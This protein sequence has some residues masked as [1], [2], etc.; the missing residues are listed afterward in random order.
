MTTEPLPVPVPDT[1]A[2]E[3]ESRTFLRLPLTPA[4]VELVH[5]TYAAWE[6]T[7]TGPL[8]KTLPGNRHRPIGFLPLQPA[9]TAEM[10]DSYYYRRGV[11]LP[12]ALCDQ[13][14]ALI[15]LLAPVARKIGEQIAARG[16]PRLLR[17]T[18]RGC[19]RVMRYPPFEGDI[20][21]AMVRQ[22]AQRGT[23][24][25]PAHKD[26]N[27]LTILAPA[28]LPGLQ[29]EGPDGWAEVHDAGNELIVHT[30][31]EMEDRSGRRW[32]AT[33]HRVRNPEPGDPQLAR[34]SCAY[35]V[36]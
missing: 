18:D 21:S 10:K 36:S 12:Q 3:L 29:I 6:R 20:D 24:R 11:R 1:A 15:A 2:A 14:D 25:S 30:G 9:F 26:L 5:V 33:V 7:L 28:S 27:A 4:Q 17:R 13:T 19:L 23:P 8:R 35:F 16:G 32:P 31:Q 34:M 22:R